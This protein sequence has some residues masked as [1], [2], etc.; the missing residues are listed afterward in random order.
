MGRPK[1]LISRVSQPVHLVVLESSV[2]ST[3][4]ENGEKHGLEAVAK[5]LHGLA[6]AAGIL[7]GL[8]FAVACY[9]EMIGL[10]HFE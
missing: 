6:F 4:P 7:L 8:A 5:V 10:V 1:E 2:L 9:A 3:E